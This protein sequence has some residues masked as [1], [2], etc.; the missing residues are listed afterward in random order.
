MWPILKTFSKGSSIHAYLAVFYYI[1]L[2]ISVTDI[3]KGPD[4]AKGPDNKT[5]MSIYIY[6]YIY[7]YMWTY[8]F[9]Y[10][11]LVVWSFFSYRTNIS[12]LSHL[13]MNISVLLY[14]FY[15]ISTDMSK[16]DISIYN[17]TYRFYFIGFIAIVIKF[18]IIYSLLHLT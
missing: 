11:G 17:W 14:R 4:T 7:I 12:I 1:G 16:T 15:F 18:Y 2:D 3:S 9:Y 10:I 6:I 8:R 13:K 5:D